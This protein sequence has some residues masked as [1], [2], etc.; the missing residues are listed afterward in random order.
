M[1]PLGIA[2]WAWILFLTSLG[3]KPTVQLALELYVRAR[4]RDDWPGMAARL[5][6]PCPI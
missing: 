1:V 3:L 6:W 2:A 4:E 5:H